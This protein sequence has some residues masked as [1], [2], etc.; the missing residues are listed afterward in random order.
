MVKKF[1][2]WFIR[3]HW[4]DHYIRK[5]EGVVHDAILR[6][7]E[8]EAALSEKRHKVEIVRLTTR[9]E[10]EK[11]IATSELKAEVSRLNKLLEESDVK[12]KTAE[13]LYSRAV[14]ALKGNV[15]LSA[16]MGRQVKYATDT[17]AGIFG[18]IKGVEKDAMANMK[19]LT[20][21]VKIRRKSVTGTHTVPGTRP[22]ELVPSASNV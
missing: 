17:L 12:T 20:G 9:L 10:T 6:A 13:E 3:K 15:S 14:E 4:A 7:R 11:L 22:P 1:V 16:E 8:D 19:K 18:S 21:K 2:D 5:D